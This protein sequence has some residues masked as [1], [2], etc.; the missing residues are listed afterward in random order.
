MNSFF[1][2]T[3]YWHFLLFRVLFVT[4]ETAA[5]FNGLT[6]VISAFFYCCRTSQQRLYI[7]LYHFKC[8]LNIFFHNLLLFI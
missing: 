5:A 1:R 6:I 4:K 3:S 2:R 7:Q 8:R